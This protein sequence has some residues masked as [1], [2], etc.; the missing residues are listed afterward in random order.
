L[1]AIGAAWSG[2]ETAALEAALALHR[3]GTL[4][5]PLADLPAVTIHVVEDTSDGLAAV[6]TA[7]EA[8]RAA[9]FRVEWQAYGIASTGSPKAVSLAAEGA[10]IYP[11]V[12]EAV[13][14]ALQQV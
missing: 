9:G 10:L 2:Q 5:P 14:A 8:L 13:L 3:D 1:A 4:Y 6:K 11:S 7:V 12:N